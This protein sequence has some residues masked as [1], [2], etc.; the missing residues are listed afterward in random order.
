[1]FAPEWLEPLAR[2]LGALGAEH[3]WLVHGA[4]GLDEIS[5]TG[6]TEIVAWE[7][8]TIRH[9]TIAPEHVGVPRAT[10]ADLKG[11]DASYNAAALRDVLANIAGPYRDIACLNAAAALVVAGRADDLRAGLSLARDALDSGRARKV[12]E[13]LVL[14]SHGA[15]LAPAG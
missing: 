9:F 1:M 6:P 4:D 13:R 10:L 8:G 3:A 15:A 11:G 14:V 5:T 2:V 7:H 12:L